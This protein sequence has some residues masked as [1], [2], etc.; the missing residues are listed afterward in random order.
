MSTSLGATEHQSCHCG[1][2]LRLARCCALDLAALSPLKASRHLGPLVECAN[3]ALDQDDTATAERLC[4]EV[5]E[6]APSLT[7]L[8]A[9]LQAEINAGKVELS[10]EPRGL[11]VSLKQTAFFPSG[12]DLN[13]RIR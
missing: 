3:A 11:V 7:S 1:S 12:A 5:L 2:G 10:L 6:L 9:E 8:N 13:H 4:L